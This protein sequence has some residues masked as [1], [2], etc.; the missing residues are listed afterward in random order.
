MRLECVISQAPRPNLQITVVNNSALRSLTVNAQN[1]P[2][3]P[4]SI[5][6]VQGGIV[7]G[8]GSG[9]SAGYNYNQPVASVLWI[10]NHNLG[11]KPGVAVFTVGGV[12]QEGTAVHISV[13]Q[14]QVQFVLPTAGFA[15]LI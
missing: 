12:E 4:V 1:P 5:T 7:S 9:G 3:P 15:R 10:I 14:V 6:V 2:R 8:G 13:N 11:Y